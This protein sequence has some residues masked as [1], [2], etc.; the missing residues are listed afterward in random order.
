M[1]NAESSSILSDC[2]R[3]DSWTTGFAEISVPLA[4]ELLIL[5]SSCSLLS[6]TTL[7]ARC[8]RCLRPRVILREYA[9][10]MDF[11]VR[12]LRDNSS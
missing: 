11:V 8:L 6:S 7:S 1:L 12:I 10:I 3:V 9:L 5:T 2:Q 4:M